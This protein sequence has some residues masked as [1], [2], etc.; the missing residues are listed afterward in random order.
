MGWH[1]DNVDPD[2]PITRTIKPDPHLILKPSF[3]PLFFR[4]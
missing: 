1:V 4:L 2:T 3:N